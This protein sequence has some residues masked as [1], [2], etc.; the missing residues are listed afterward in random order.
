MA[1]PIIGRTP[2]KAAAAERTPQ[3]SVA[4]TPSSST[5][6]A[7][8]AADREPIETPVTLDDAVTLGAQLEG[9]PHRPR[10]IELTRQCLAEVAPQLALVYLHYSRM[11]GVGTLRE[12]TRLRFVGLQQLAKDC[13]LETKDFDLHS[14][15]RVMSLHAE[16]R[17]GR[18]QSSSGGKDG[19]PSAEDAELRLEQCARR[20]PP[21][22]C[23]APC[24]TTVVAR[25]L[26][27]SRA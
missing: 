3:R 1:Q 6:A 24:A 26:L 12:A 5:A 21:P 22:P 4:P 2:Q 25:R 7:T 8:A 15:G 16:E 14:M 20:A 27:R 11:S 23:P 9:L 13:L 10:S 18:R 17:S 19:G